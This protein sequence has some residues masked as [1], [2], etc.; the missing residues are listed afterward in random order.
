V[1]DPNDTDGN[2]LLD[3]W[4]MT[5]FGHLG[6]DPN[7]DPDGDGLTN[8]QEYQNGTDPNSADTDGDGV[9]D[10]TEL[11]TTHTSPT[12]YYNGSTP[13]ITTISGTGQSGPP[14]YFL[15][16]PWVLKV[17]D[18]AGNPQANAPVTFTA[19]GATV[20]FSTAN[21]D[22]QPVLATL[23]V[24]TNSEGLASAYWKL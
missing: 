6:V 12:D 2:E 24:R 1:V 4:E 18:S 11:N 8:L 20:G 9:S 23:T 15:L 13:T 17:I 14:G 19:T 16:Y 22:S 10:Y 21:D 3:T 5:H 7:A